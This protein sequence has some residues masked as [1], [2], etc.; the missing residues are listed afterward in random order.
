MGNRDLHME[1]PRKRMGDQH[2][3]QA[4]VP[5]RQGGHQGGVPSQEPGEEGELHAAVLDPAHLG[6]PLGAEEEQAL[7]VEVEPGEGHDR[8]VEPVLLGDQQL[9]D[10]A[11]LELHHPEVVLG[12][13]GLEE[14]GVHGE[15]REVLDVRVVLQAVGDD[16]VDVVGCLPPSNRNPS[17]QVP[18]NHPDVV[19]RP[20]LEGHRPMPDV[21]PEERHLLPESSHEKSPDGPPDHGGF[22]Q[23]HAGEGDGK[24]QGVPSE[25]TEIVQVGGGEVALGLEVLVQLHVLLVHG[26]PALLPVHRVANA[27]FLQSLPNLLRMEGSILHRTILASH[28]QNRQLTTR[29]QVH[30]CPHVVHP[31]IHH[32]PR[33]P[34]AAVLGHL[35]HRVLLSRC[36]SLT[37]A[38]RGLGGLHTGVLAHGWRGPSKVEDPTDS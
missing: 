19:L 7:D 14:P 37:L 23:Q 27:E 38:Q 31:A 8:E 24:Q 25:L 15:D 33:V 1:D 16:V 12:V 35:C 2:E 10:A 20:E 6:P 34:L 30:P 3:P 26:T 32:N 18:R 28:P 4:L 22:T 17:Q 21:M 29:V 13:Q 9:A 36:A 11:V 5:V